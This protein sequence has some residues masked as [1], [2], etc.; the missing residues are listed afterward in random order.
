M[1]FFGKQQKVGYNM[2]FELL[3]SSLQVLGENS[4]VGVLEKPTTEALLCVSCFSGSWKQEN[5]MMRH[6]SYF[7]FQHDT[8]HEGNTTSVKNLPER[9]LT[10]KQTKRHSDNLI[11]SESKPM[12]VLVCSL[13]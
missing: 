12:C 4:V 11:E 9:F 2:V 7:T 10:Q 1:C 13:S 3:L 8:H 6:P 5:W